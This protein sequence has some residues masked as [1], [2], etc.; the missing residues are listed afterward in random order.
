MRMKSVVLRKDGLSHEV[1]L[2]WD[3]CV[4]AGYTG[5][6]QE[7][8]RAHVEE[9]K[10]IGVP[11]PYAVPA[12]YWV[13]PERVSTTTTLWVV[14]DKTP[15]EGEVFLA[16]CAKGNLYVTVASDHTDRALEAVSVSKAKQACSKVVGSICWRVDE[17]RG[18]WDDIELRVWNDG[19]LYQEGTL[20]KM[21]PPE[22]LFELAEADAPV[23]GGTLSLFSGTLPVI[24][25]GLVYGVHYLLSLKDPVLGRELRHEYDVRILPDRN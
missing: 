14:G 6:D 4:A 24:G 16:R 19:K 25:G 8:V 1:R 15:G 7:S 18:H 17:V 23:K 13:E 12:M 10:K 3:A 21:L 11:A 20:G 22:R 2:A 5:R 9:L